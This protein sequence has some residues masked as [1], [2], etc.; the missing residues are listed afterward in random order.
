MRISRYAWPLALGLGALVLAG[1]GKQAAST[2]GNGSPRAA[3]ETSIKALKAGHFD[4]LMHNLLPPVDYKTMR[5]DWS[6]DRG[7]P[8]RITPAQRTQ[9][10]ENMKRLTQPGAKDALYK[11]VEPRIEAF[12]SKYKAQLPMMVGIGQ[13]VADTQLDNTKTLTLTQKKQAKDLV[14]ALAGWAKQ[15][16]WGDKA[17]ARQAV[18]TLVDTARSLDLKTFDQV[19]AL[20]YAQAMAKYGQVWQGAKKVLA[21][22]GL[23]LDQIFDSA[24]VETVD[25]DGKQAHVR[26]DYT[27]LD[28]PM[29]TQLTLVQRDGHWY[30]KDVL[31]NWR[32]AHAHSSG[33]TPAASTAAGVVAQ[34][35]PMPAA[36]SAP[37]AAASA[38]PGH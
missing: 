25:N 22:Y 11:Q 17:K 10:A 29:S 26:V 32:R 34:S 12:Q 2:G 18:G 23:S 24:K 20:D 28:K 27:V 36:S 15:A 6:K 33:P 21:L 5:A 37:A 31:D 38:A 1:C 19:Y 8:S 3:V 13:T 16:P 7:D 4:A 35:A 30:D 14:S 9:F